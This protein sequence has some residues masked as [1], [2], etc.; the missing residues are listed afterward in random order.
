M[1]NIK[2]MLT[3]VTG[4]CEIIGFFFLPCMVWLFHRVYKNAYCLLK[5]KFSTWWLIS[6]KIHNS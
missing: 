1:L 2:K 4:G 5:I 6:G 3:D